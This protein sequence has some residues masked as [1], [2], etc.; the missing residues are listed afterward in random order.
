MEVLSRLATESIMLRSS[1]S[2]TRLWHDRPSSGFSR[3]TGRREAS[4]SFALSL[5]SGKSQLPYARFGPIPQRAV[6]HRSCALLLIAQRRRAHGASGG[7]TFEGLDL[8]ITSS[9]EAREM[10]S[11]NGSA[12]VVA[13]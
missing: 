13:F 9:D 10:F 11:L 7:E 5:R 1:K 8:E 4:C 3:S 12:D 6:A 2:S